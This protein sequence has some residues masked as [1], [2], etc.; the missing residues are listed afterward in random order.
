MAVFKRGKTWT[1]VYYVTDENG[2]RRQKWKGGFR[3]K[4]EAERELAR[5]THALHTGTYVE[6]SRMTVAEYL[7]YWLEN[8][9]K[10]NVAP[11]TYSRYRIIV[12]G[13]LIPALGGY[14]LSNLQPHLIQ[15]YYTDALQS[16]RRDGKGGL[17]KRTVLHHHRVLREALQHAVRWQMIVRNP[18]DAVEPPRPEREERPFLDSQQVALL[19][20]KA[21]G[22]RLYVPILLAVTTGM[23]RGEILALRWQD[24]D[25][26][27]ATATVVRNL[28]RAEGKLEFGEPKTPRSRRTVTLP[29]I[30]VEALRR[31][32]VQQARE[33]LRL[34]PAY[35]DYG[36]VCAQTNGK[37]YDPREFS[38]AFTRLAKRA[39]FPNLR[40][41]D[42]RHTHASLLLRGGIHP[43]VVSERL[44]HST[45]SITLD[46]Y[47]HVVPSLQQEAAR[48]VDED[49]RA[50]LA[51]GVPSTP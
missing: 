36:L 40:F 2:K 43:K 3:T 27:K 18:A 30:T 31:H 1:I 17:S 33:K 49:L 23:R 46:T 20:Q 11:S 39:G 16:G 47:S 10:T 15:Q 34:G 13:H 24:V 44:G 8:Y 14:R 45:V 19:L 29:P 35:E 26:D 50:A 22:S 41:H 32:K 21:E 5:I 25:F 48:A 42:L 7:R 28:I 51:G 4:K 37:P 12:E 6:P 9:A 38:K